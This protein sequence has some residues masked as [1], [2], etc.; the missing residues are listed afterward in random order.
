MKPRLYLLVSYLGRY[1]SMRKKKKEMRGKEKIKEKEWIQGMRSVKKDVGRIFCRV[2]YE[3]SGGLPESWLRECMNIPGSRRTELCCI[4]LFSLNLLSEIYTW[5]SLMFHLCCS[6]STHMKKYLLLP[7]LLVFSWGPESHLKQ[8]Y[9]HW[10][11]FKWPVGL[12]I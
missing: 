11:G 4:M 5:A 3:I 12:R 10:S 1:K 8:A 7:V 2:C 6:F 9:R